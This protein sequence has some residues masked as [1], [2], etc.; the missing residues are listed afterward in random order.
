MSPKMSLKV[1]LKVA[2]KMILKVILKVMHL[3]YGL[4]NRLEEIQ[5]LLLK[6]WQGQVKR[7]LRPS[8]AI[9]QNSLIS[10]MSVVAIAVIGKLLRT[11]LGRN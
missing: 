9:L 2:L 10:N 4:K 11:M 5:K 6:N 8:N 7:D 3:I 1:A